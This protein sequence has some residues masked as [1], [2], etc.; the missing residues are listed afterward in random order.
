[1]CCGSRDHA[2]ETTHH[3]NTVLVMV[4]ESY[5]LSFFS[6]AASLHGQGASAF[7]PFRMASEIGMSLGYSAG[8]KWVWVCVKE[9]CITTQ[10]LEPSACF[11]T[12]RS[13]CWRDGGKSQKHT[14]SWAEC[15]DNSE[16]PLAIR[17]PPSSLPSLQHPHSTGTQRLLVNSEG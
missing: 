10:R 15:K 5:G 1:M 13:T 4:V 16:R 9:G 17:A 11:T 14:G 3:R 6:Q 12:K 8:L 2:L 7:I